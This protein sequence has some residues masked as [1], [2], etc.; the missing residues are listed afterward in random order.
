MRE[1]KPSSSAPATRAQGPTSAPLPPPNVAPC[2]LH[3]LPNELLKEILSLAAEA[4]TSSRYGQQQRAFQLSGQCRLWRDLLSRPHAYVAMDSAMAQRLAEKLRIEGAGAHVHKLEIHYVSSIWVNGQRLAGIAIPELLRECPRLRELSLIG[5]CDRIGSEL[6]SCLPTL[7]FLE[8]LFLDVTQD[9]AHTVWGS[10]P[11]S[12]LS[13]IASCPRLLHLDTGPHYIPPP[14]LLPFP[15]GTGTRLTYIK[16]ELPRSNKHVLLSSIAM[17]LVS[18]L[19]S[20]Y[21]GEF[22]ALD[23][24]LEIVTN[25]ILPLAPH[26]INFGW[27]PRCIAFPYT[28]GAEDSCIT[29]LVPFFKLRSV[30]A[31]SLYFNTM[32]SPDVLRNQSNLCHLTLNLGYYFWSRQEN[33]GRINAFLSSPTSHNLTRLHLHSKSPSDF[34]LPSLQQLQLKD[35]GKCY[36]VTVVID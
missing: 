17:A 5:L 23:G 13:I 27:H 31:G 32:L 30:K 29:M 33:I 35:K 26:L 3:R 21:L 16:T 8:R 10:L 7:S 28:D 20:L 6:A 18:S 2:L 1:K 12:F 11:K 22:I 9:S 14:D 25:A 36:G 19:T 4:E 24:Q 15:V 34:K